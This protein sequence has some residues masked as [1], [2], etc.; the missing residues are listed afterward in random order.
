MPQ[1][2][3]ALRNADG[4]PTHSSASPRSFQ[5]VRYRSNSPCVTS[6]IIQA[7][8]RKSEFQPIN[9]ALCTVAHVSFL[10]PF[11]RQKPT[12]VAGVLDG[13]TNGKHMTFVIVDALTIL[14]I[15]GGLLIDAAAYP[16]PPST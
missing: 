13:W 12:L 3:L 8:K 7:L 2:P 6:S 15:I 4:G 16:Q 14:P 10:L 9:I 5:S 1:P 11:G